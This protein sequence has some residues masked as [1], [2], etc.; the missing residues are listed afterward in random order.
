[1][2][3]VIAAVGSFFDTGRLPSE[4]KATISALVPKKVNRILA[5]R[6]LPCLH[7]IISLNQSCHHT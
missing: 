3:D 7:G 5:N 1:M 6:M 2:V 4:V